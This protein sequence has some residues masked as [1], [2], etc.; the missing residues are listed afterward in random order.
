MVVI[1]NSYFIFYSFL[2]FLSYWLTTCLSH[3]YF[4][5]GD[6]FRQSS[7]FLSKLQRAIKRGDSAQPS[8]VIW[9]GTALELANEVVAGEVSQRIQS[10]VAAIWSWHMTNWEQPW[11]LILLQSKLP[12]QSRQTGKHTG[13]VT[14]LAGAFMNWHSIVIRSCYSAQSQ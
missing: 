4:I 9:S 1:I 11:K 12:V 5:C 10:V 7:E 8:S 2:F 3:I 14:Q 13:V 6:N